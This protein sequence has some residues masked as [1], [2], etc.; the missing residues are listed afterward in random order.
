[1]INKII[2]LNS[3]TD[4]QAIDALYTSEGYKCVQIFQ[5]EQAQWL[6]LLEKVANIYPYGTPTINQISKNI[7]ASDRYKI[8]NQSN[9]TYRSMVENLANGQLADLINDVQNLIGSDTLGLSAETIAVLNF[10]IEQIEAMQG[11]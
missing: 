2:Q 9:G 7:A 8:Q 1:M 4:T 6:A 11:G 3:A 5:N 10:V